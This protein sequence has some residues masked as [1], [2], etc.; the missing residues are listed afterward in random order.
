MM[1]SR[2]GPSETP[3]RGFA[4]E[5][6]EHE[7]KTPLTSMRAFTE[8]LRDYPDLGEGE[9]RRLLGL[10]VAESERL[11]RTIERLLGGPKL[12]QALG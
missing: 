10:L 2:A 6:V 4:Y 9:R 7:L 1:V 5:E 3:P 11:A 12:Q 8:I